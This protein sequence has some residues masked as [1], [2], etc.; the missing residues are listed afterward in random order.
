[1]AKIF[2]DTRARKAESNGR[3]EHGYCTGGMR[4]EYW[5][6]AAMIQRCTNPNNKSYKNYGGRGIKVAKRWLK[7]SNFIEDMGARPDDKLTVEQVHEIRALLKRGVRGMDI[8]KQYGVSKT[9]ITEIKKG[10]THA[11]H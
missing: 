7:F 3:Y 4:K 5:V 10:R 1:M 8:A 9:T 6:W 11:Y 2:W